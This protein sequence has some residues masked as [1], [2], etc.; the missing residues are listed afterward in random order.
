MIGGQQVFNTPSLSDTWQ[1]WSSDTSIK[2]FTFD[3]SNMQQRG[4]VLEMDGL[5]AMPVP[6]LSTWLAGALLLGAM[7]WRGVREVRARKVAMARITRR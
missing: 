4:G 1:G 3:Y 6:E 7:T 5:Q 2:S